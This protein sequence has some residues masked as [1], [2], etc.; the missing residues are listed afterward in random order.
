MQSRSCR[1]EFSQE[2][3]VGP[4]GEEKHPASSLAREVGSEFCFCSHLSFCLCGGK[5][6]RLQR[7]VN[8]L[9]KLKGVKKANCIH[10][11][12]VCATAANGLDSMMNCRNAEDL[13]ETLGS[14]V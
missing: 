7:R 3:G 9:D 1:G 11:A 5:V 12:C 8:Y 13:L 4:G 14:E 2:L 10:T 6:F